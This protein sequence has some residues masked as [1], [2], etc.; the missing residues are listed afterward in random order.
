VS[1]GIT[2]A[3]SESTSRREDADRLRLVALPFGP[4]NVNVSP[5]RMLFASV[6]RFLMRLVPGTR[7]GRWRRRRDD[8]VDR[9]WVDAVDARVRVDAA[10]AARGHVHASRCGLRR[11]RTS[12]RCPSRSAT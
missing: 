3:F 9:P 8:V 1:F 10:I 5:I 2:I 6:K 12:G 7:R 11:L 4:R